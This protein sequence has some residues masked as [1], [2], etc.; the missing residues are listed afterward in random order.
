MAHHLVEPTT[1][2]RHRRTQGFDALGTVDRF[3]SAFQNQRVAKL[4]LLKV[5]DLTSYNVSTSAPANTTEAR[6]KH[7]PESPR[8][9][10]NGA[11]GSMQ[12]GY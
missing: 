2:C 3:G 8:N 5:V 10:P 9:Q 11:C 1:S 4:K 7:R 6:R 12:S